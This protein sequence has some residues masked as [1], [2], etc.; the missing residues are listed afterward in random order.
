ML[1]VYE[2]RHEISNNMV[3]ATSKALIR[4]IASRLN[5]LLTDHHLEFLSLSGGCTG[6]SES[7]HV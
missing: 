3:R 5:I 1:K 2:P 7:T 6:S 4:A